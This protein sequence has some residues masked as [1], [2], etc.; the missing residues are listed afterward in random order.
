MASTCCHPHEVMLLSALDETG[1]SLLHPNLPQPCCMIA[2]IQTMWSNDTRLSGIRIHERLDRWC[3]GCMILVQYMWGQ[4]GEVTFL[5]C[6]QTKVQCQAPA[7]LPCELN[8]RPIMHV[9]RQYIAKMDW[10]NEVGNDLQG[11]KASC[12]AA[13]YPLHAQFLL[14]AQSPQQKWS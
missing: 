9:A 5:P 7:A 8:D 14:H 6:K 4:H 3:M 11:S 2:T 1:M 10:Q 13:S 12:K